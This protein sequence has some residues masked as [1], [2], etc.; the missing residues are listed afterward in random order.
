MRLI[1]HSGASLEPWRRGVQWDHS[2]PM[3]AH[4]LAGWAFKAAECRLQPAGRCVA[5]SPWGLRLMLQ[6]PTLTFWFLPPAA[7]WRDQGG[8]GWY[9]L[10]ELWPMADS[11]ILL[12]SPAIVFPYVLSGDVDSDQAPSCIFCRHLGQLRNVTT[13]CLLCSFPGS[14]PHSLELYN[15]PPPPTK[16]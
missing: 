16:C 6:M 13:S 8:G 14:L 5:G 1:C 10:G 7:A 2:G 9:P 15:S 12:S 3:H 11:L 4:C